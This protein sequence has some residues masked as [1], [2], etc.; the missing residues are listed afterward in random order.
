MRDQRTPLQRRVDDIA[1]SACDAAEQARKAAEL[2]HTLLRDG[3]RRPSGRVCF[4]CGRHD[5]CG[6]REPEL[7]RIHGLM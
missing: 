6:H 7:L 2:V 3:P 1:S 4:I 5:I